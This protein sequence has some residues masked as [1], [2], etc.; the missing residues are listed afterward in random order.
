MDLYTHAKHRNVREKLWTGSMNLMLVSTKS[1]QSYSVQLT[2]CNSVSPQ[3]SPVK[4]PQ[5]LTDLITRSYENPLVTATSRSIIHD[6]YSLAGKFRAVDVPRPL[7][8][9]NTLFRLNHQSD[10]MGTHEWGDGSEPWF[11]GLRVWTEIGEITESESFG[12]STLNCSLVRSLMWRV[13][14]DTEEVL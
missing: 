7:A 8:V 6:I 12:R 11:Q 2:C 5:R 4:S 3:P 13:Q 9:L 14:M 10:L 1:H